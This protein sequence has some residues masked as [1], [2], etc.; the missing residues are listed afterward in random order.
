MVVPKNPGVDSAKAALDGTSGFGAEMLPTGTA[1][2]IIKRIFDQ[3]WVRKSLMAMPMAEQTV[4]VPKITAGITMQGTT[5][6]TDSEA[7]ES[8]QTTDEVQLSMKTIIGNVPI[9]KKFIAYSK[10]SA[11][12]AIKDDIANTVIQTEEDMFINGDTTAATASTNINRAYHATNYPNGI[13][14][15]DPRLEF[16][17]L[18]KIAMDGSCSVNASGANL[19]PAHILEAFANLGIYARNPK[20]ILI[21]VSHSVRSLMLGWDEL[22]KRNE[23]GPGATILTGEIGKLYGATV[24]TSSLIPETLGTGGN[25][26]SQASGSTGNRTVVLV[27]NKRSPIIGNPVKSERKFRVVI[28]D[29]PEKDRI[30]LIP[31]LDLAFAN[32]WQEAICHIL[33]VA[34]GTS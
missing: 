21:I 24:V 34:P 30:I 28:K 33:N 4:N 12:P 16:D 3:S 25:A 5:G 18:R 10:T 6:Q 27:F 26:R 19:T 20:D 11:M 13:A 31:K 2:E 23:Y 14:S 8:R 9:S 32:R 15:R 1:L 7:D 17:G 29:K 22:E